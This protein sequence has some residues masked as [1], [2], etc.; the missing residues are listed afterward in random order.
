[1][2]FYH[3][4]KTKSLA[5]FLAF[6]FLL[7]ASGLFA[8][9]LMTDITSGNQA[10]TE[11]DFADAVAYYKKATDAGY[12]SPELFYNVG[13]AYFKLNEFPQAIL[14][15]ERAQRLDP[16]NEDIDYNLNVANSKIADKIDPLPELFYV[17]WYRSVVDL[18]PTS[19]WAVQTIVFFILTLV[20]VSLYFISRKLFLRKAG[21]WAAILC[22]ALT[23][24]TLLF[25]I[26]GHYR[27]KSLHEAIIFDPTIT[28]KSSP[29]EQ[30]VDL[31]VIHEG[32][33]VQ[34]LD[35][36]GEW[37]EIRIANGSVGWLPAESLEE[38]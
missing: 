19:T 34:L 35:K 15:Y 1:M 13:N 22:I 31:F 23:I 4:I 16:G 27:M 20:S 28:V 7:F 36:I 26:S 5:G 37:H 17:R 11:G 9:D 18:Y 24:F 30:S 2:T 3:N 21:F 6:S 14:W 32:T 8:Q 25:S 12:E 10:Y 38:I 29:D 33:K